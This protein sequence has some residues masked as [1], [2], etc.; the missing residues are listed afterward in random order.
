MNLAELKS[1]L[2]NKCVPQEFY[3]L[4]GGLPADAF[5][6]EQ[7]ADGKWRT[8]YGE[9]GLRSHINDFETEEAACD[10]FY[11]WVRNDSYL[12]QYFD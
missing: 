7:L 3:S 6:I 11:N 4:T 1:I 10:F 5:C 12:G 9:R 8:Y 2:E